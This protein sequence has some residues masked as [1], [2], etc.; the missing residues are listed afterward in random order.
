MKKY[1]LMLVLNTILGTDFLVMN[2]AEA[3]ESTNARTRD[4]I[5]NFWKEKKTEILDAQQKK[6]SDVQ[7]PYATCI[8]RNA[9]SGP[10][11]KSVEKSWR[12]PKIS[13]DDN[14]ILSEK[15]SI[16]SR[17]LLE[18]KLKK[19]NCNE[20]KGGASVPCDF[21]KYFYHNET[22]DLWKEYFPFTNYPFPD[23]DRYGELEDYQWASSFVQFL[24]GYTRS[25]HSNA[26]GF[27]PLVS[28]PPTEICDESFLQE[29]K[30]K[31][32]LIKDNKT[33][34]KTKNKKNKIQKDQNPK[35][36]EE[37]KDENPKPTEKNDADQLGRVG[38]IDM[39]FTEKKASSFGQKWNCYEQ[40]FDDP[41]PREG[42]GY[43]KPTQRL[44]GSGYIE[45]TDP[46][47]LEKDNGRIVFDYVNRRVYYTPT[48]YVAQQ[49]GKEPLQQ[50]KACLTDVEECINP[51]V[52]IVLPQEMTQ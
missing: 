13:V 26:N 35:S 32:M 18:T 49:L 8:T 52:E 22:A 3:I 45:I 20:T 19:E 23:V 28:V 36:T 4:A 10:G 17:L 1:T 21:I 48:H 42:R 2:T 24:K 11:K 43:I 31:N 9:R 38:V 47:L 29:I 25:A 12:I 50:W 51:F 37:K 27:L 14:R 44:N 46:D 30:E 15:L 7:L 6:C 40:I 39:L 41:K 33:E 16:L 34:D 5:Q